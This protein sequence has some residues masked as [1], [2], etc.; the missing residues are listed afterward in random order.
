MRATRLWSQMSDRNE[1]RSR[2]SGPP[3]PADLAQRTTSLAGT[4]VRRPAVASE[5]A[6]Y[7]PR[8]AD[9]NA[10]ASIRAPVPMLTKTDDSSSAE[11]ALAAGD[12]QSGEFCPDPGPVPG[13]ERHT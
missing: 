13:C 4:G 2:G 5:D 7:R 6:A 1:D 8:F 11:I 3:I 9:S 12:R 10:M